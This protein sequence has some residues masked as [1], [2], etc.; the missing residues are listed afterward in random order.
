[1]HSQTKARWSSV[2]W[3]VLLLLA[4]LPLM[5]WV[6]MDRYAVHPY[7]LVRGDAEQDMAYT[8]WAWVRYGLMS[9][10]HPGTPVFL[11]H[12]GLFALLGSGI[13]AI[14]AFLFWSHGLV[15]LARSVTVVLWGRWAS[16]KG[17]AFPWIVLMLALWMAHP[18]F[19]AFAELLN[20]DSYLPV[21][22]LWFLSAGWDVLERPRWRNV[23]AVG[24][25]G[26]VLLSV[27]FAAAPLVVA[28]GIA[29]GWRLLKR[30]AQWGKP[31]MLGGVALTTFL[32][33]ASYPR[34]P[35]FGLRL[36][37]G[38]LTRRDVRFQGMEAFARWR[39]VLAFQD[40][41]WITTLPLV[42]GTLGLLL[43]WTLYRLAHQREFF[44]ARAS[45]GVLWVLLMMAWLYT[46]G[47]QAK[48]IP[49]YLEYSL[50]VG[51]RLRN[52]Y[53]P[54][55]GFVLLLGWL[56]LF[57]KPRTRGVFFVGAQVVVL[58]VGVLSWGAFLQERDQVYQMLGALHIAV[59]QNLQ[60]FMDAEGESVAFWATKG[61]PI[62]D[63]AAFHWE[64][65]YHPGQ[66]R[67]SEE[68]SHHYPRFVLF[69]LR[70]VPQELERLPPKPGPSFSREDCR[71]A[72]SAFEGSASPG[73][74]LFPSVAYGV[75]PRWVVYWT[76]VEQKLLRVTTD[77]VRWALC[78]YGWSDVVTEFRVGKMVW[79]LLRVE[80]FYEEGR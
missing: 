71:Q 31:L 24:L 75:H 16:R 35:V 49:P 52:T 63:E 1:M 23:L 20:T 19:L 37:K 70:R 61:L 80:P 67:F 50:N 46:I 25:L 44:T 64:G 68:I 2:E 6:W 45:Q 56:V 62:V 7:W 18:T 69:A 3:G 59:R 22:G 8:A 43:L 30:P 66:G 27:K 79:I 40:V 13:D 33:L 10:R 17:I 5:L 53:L 54:T 14:P 78:V 58:S 72:Y 47:A 74:V 12:S 65:N 29:L 34:S 28:V 60:H 36:L 51:Y 77:D 26:G 48:D 39:D 11:L 76:W 42:Y 41:Y 55:L 73:A 32:L 57:W 4:A 38:F 9:Y 21:L 15:A